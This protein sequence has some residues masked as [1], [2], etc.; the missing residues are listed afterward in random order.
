MWGGMGSEWY[1]GTDAKANCR[2]C[3]TEE[4][5]ATSPDCCCWD[6]PF[7]MILQSRGWGGGYRDHLRLRVVADK[8][9]THGFPPHPT[10]VLHIYY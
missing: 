10:F 2:S 5:W 9:P 6:F 3:A 4:V 8:P 7:T 1:R